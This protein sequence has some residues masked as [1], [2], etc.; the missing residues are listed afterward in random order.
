MKKINTTILVIL[1]LSITARAQ[2]KL[3]TTTN[4]L[5]YNDGK[6]GV[7]INTPSYQLQIRSEESK[8]A[9]FQYRGDANYPRLNIVGYS[10]KIGLELDASKT[11]ATDIVFSNINEPNALVING[12]GNIGLG[13]ASPNYKLVLK[14]KGNK[15]AHFQYLDTDGLA[16]YPRLSIEADSYNI[17]FKMEASK[18]SATDLTFSAVNFDNALVIKGNGNIEIGDI[19]TGINVNDYRLSVNGKV[20]AREMEVN[21]D[22]WAD[23]V[24]EDNHK[25]MPLNEVEDYIIENN[26]LPDVPS[27]K[28]VKE[29]GISLG[30][31]DAIL[32]QKIEEL[33]LHLIEQNK[34]LDSV[35][36]ENQLLK[37]ELS[38][39]N[40]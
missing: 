25:L 15:L 31:M 33:T 28:E 26:H 36:V 20:R 7:G 10:T 13:T 5:Y 35:I 14:S 16:N 37:E 3:N 21:G 23:F 39:L 8:I 29:N 34:R 9:Q 40:K 1:L 32:L 30:K 2:F 12:D 11:S 19:T 17:G 18:T 6:I 27:A 38:K 4:D 22:S 24:F